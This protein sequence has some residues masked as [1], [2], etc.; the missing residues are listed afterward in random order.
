ME[1]YRLQRTLTVLVSCLIVTGSIGFVAIEGWS[2]ADSLYMTI[3]T[4]STVGFGET[5]ELTPHGRVFTSSLILASLVLMACWTAGITS[6]LVNGQ[7]SG[8]FHRLRTKKK[9]N[10]MNNHVV[11]CGGGATARTLIHQL[12]VQGNEIAAIV[13]EPAEVGMTQRFFPDIALIEADPKS[14]MALIDA[15]ILEAAHLVAATESDF[16]NLLIV[17]SGKGLGTELKVISVAENPELAN[18]MLKVGADEV[19]CP[20][21]IGG[22]RIA[23][24]INENAGKQESVVAP[25]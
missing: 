25:V 12:K 1:T 8:Q 13:N 21:V 15:N 4:M 7:L 9:I 20:L 23:S 3:I 6:F 16:D 14:E 19:V 24:I 2:F 17:I 10:Q 22:E 5:N 11:V 18:R